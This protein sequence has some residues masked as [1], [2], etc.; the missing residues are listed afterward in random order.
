MASIE[1]Y[2][3]VTCSGPIMTLRHARAQELGPWLDR[4]AAKGEV[5]VRFWLGL[6]EQAAA[7]EVGDDP[8]EEPIP[9]QLRAIVVR[10]E[11]D[12]YSVYKPQK[13]DLFLIILLTLFIVI[14]MLCR[15]S[16]KHVTKN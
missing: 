10:E 2:R 9:Q 11:G 12:R 5:F 7:F 8:P 6:G 16:H 13:S 14:F 1:L 15:A 4:V 3:P